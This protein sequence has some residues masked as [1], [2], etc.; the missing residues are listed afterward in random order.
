[1]KGKLAQTMTKGLE[2]KASLAQTFH[3]FP[4]ASQRNED[5]GGLTY[6]STISDAKPETLIE[7]TEMCGVA[8]FAFSIGH[9]RLC[10]RQC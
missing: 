9:T 1:M 2:L 7:P 5:V 8:T 4:L 6:E 10:D 3:N